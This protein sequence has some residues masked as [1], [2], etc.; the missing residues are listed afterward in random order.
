VVQADDKKKPKNCIFTIWLA[1]M[2]YQETEYPPVV[3]PERV[4]HDHHVR[5]LVPL[6]IV[7][8]VVY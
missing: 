4:R 5:Q 8:P 2:P 7:A 3:L 6:D 1:Q